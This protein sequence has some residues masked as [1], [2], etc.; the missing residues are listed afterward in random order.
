MDLTSQIAEAIN[1]WFAGLASQLLGPAL[2][3]AGQLMFQTPAFDTVPE[4]ERAWSIV[5]NTADALFV[6]ALLAVGFLVMASGTLDSRYT[7]KVLVPR[8]VLAAVLANT[9][10]AICG[11][12]ISLNNGLVQGL[13]GPDPAATTLGE[14]SSL[15]ASGVGVGQV[16][17]VVVALVAAVLAVM[18]AA[19]YIGRDIVLLL[20]T[21]LA[22]LALAA[23]ALPQTDEIARTWWRVYCALLF[24]QVVQAILVQLGL[25]LMRHT[26]WL[27]APLSDLTSGLLLVTLLF[28][29]FKLPF[30][31]YQWAFRQSFGRGPAG[32]AVFVVARA[33]RVPV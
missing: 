21:V 13:L 15:M 27:G 10:L 30:A 28:L 4:V 17:S 9:S 18:L 14:L 25:E 8:V 20:A 3:A 31:A 7:A 5:R 22:P 1:A 29:L 2:A 24:V 33:A 6:L 23:Y 32:Q 11:A 26:D 19:L 12:L 16:V